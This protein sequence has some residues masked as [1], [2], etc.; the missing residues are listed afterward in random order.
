ME[1]R[2]SSQAGQEFLQN[3]EDFKHFKS[4][5]PMKKLPFNLHIT[6]YSVSSNIPDIGKPSRAY[7]IAEAWVRAHGSPNGGSW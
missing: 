7:F 1:A 5:R 6:A 2:R 4:N 3:L